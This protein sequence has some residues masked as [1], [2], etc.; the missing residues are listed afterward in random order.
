VLD[1]GETHRLVPPYDLLCAVGANVIRERDD[2]FRRAV[3]PARADVRPVIEEVATT[4]DV[5][6]FARRSV[7]HRIGYRP[8]SGSCIDHVATLRTNPFDAACRSEP[9]RSLPISAY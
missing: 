8:L 6:G 1:L 4:D 5:I 9:P 3:A 7:K 2:F